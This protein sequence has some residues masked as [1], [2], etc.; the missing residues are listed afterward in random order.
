MKIFLDTACVAT[1][2]RLYHDK[3]IDGIT[4]NP[5]LIADYSTKHTIS[6]TEII[7]NLANITE[8]LPI[9]IEVTDHTEKGMYEQAQKWL[10]LSHNFV[11]KVPVTPTGLSLCRNLVQQGVRV[12]VTLCFSVNQ[13]ILAAKAGATYVS[14]FVG[15][16]DDAGSDGIDL[17]SKIAQVY[18][19]NNCQTQILAASLRHPWHVESALLAG[20]NIVTMP[21]SLFDKLYDHPMTKQGIDQFE[22]DWTNV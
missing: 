21:P 15:R 1:I 19:E 14:P 17:V 9:S 7:Q 16:L 13:A 22:K 18:R 6:T 3:M 11:I 20:A 5:S 2:C 8:P 10:N 4:T 12:N